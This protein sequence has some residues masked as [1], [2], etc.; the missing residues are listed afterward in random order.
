MKKMKRRNLGVFFQAALLLVMALAGAD[1]AAC[2]WDAD[3]LSTEGQRSPTLAE[4]ILADAPAAT[5]PKPLRQRIESL[6]SS[7]RTDDPAW[8]NDLAGAHIRLGE[9]QEAVKMLEPLLAKFP[10]DY[11]IH[12]NLGTAYHLL[13][14][15]QD[16]EREIARDLEINPEAH[17]GLEKYHLALLQYLIRDPE[18]QREHV[19]VDEWSKDYMSDMGFAMLGRMELLEAS[20]TKDPGYILPG[21]RAKWDLAAD[22]NFEKGV[23]YM[24]S[25]NPREPA[26]HVM[27][28]IAS[29]KAHD[30][31]LAAT[32][33]AKAVALGSPQSDMLKRETNRLR[34]FI[35]KSHEHQRTQNWTAWSLNGAFILLIAG[36]A[37]RIALV[38]KRRLAKR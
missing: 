36:I 33:F 2:I 12:A 7:P 20:S 14:R 31:N 27:L 37:I 1:V 9:S 22:P 3:T 25:L 17:F 35:Q 24:A 8:W 18:Y 11:G 16:A 26:C 28:G 4:I 6:R 38:L 13:G 32:A 21:Y 5:D 30:Y 34:E 10:D 23:I 15:Y 29:L 19:Y